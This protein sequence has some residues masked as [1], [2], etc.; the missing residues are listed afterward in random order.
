MKSKTTTIINAVSEQ[1][2]RAAKLK[3][4]PVLPELDTTFERNGRTWRVSVTT[5]SFI[6]GTAIEVP[7]GREPASADDI[8][9]INRVDL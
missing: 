9:H 7:I 2:N 8:I 3:S 6:I 5:E 4:I 1:R